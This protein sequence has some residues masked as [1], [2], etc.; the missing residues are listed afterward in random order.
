MAANTILRLDLSCI[1]FL[2]N[3]KDYSGGELVFS[4][5]AEKLSYKLK[6]G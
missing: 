1:V 4:I 2:S 3:P 6:D 5:G